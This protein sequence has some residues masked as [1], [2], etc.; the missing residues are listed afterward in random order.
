MMTEDHYPKGSEWRIWDLHVH[1]PAS[2]SVGG[3]FDDFVIQLGNSRCNVVGI[4]DYFS[5]NGYKT[6]QSYLNG[7]STPDQISD[8]YSDAL[9][10]LRKKTI[11]PVVECRMTNIVQG[12]D[13]KGNPRINFHI[14]FDNELPIDEI[15]TLIRAFN[16]SNDTTIGSKYNDAEFLLNKVSV[17]FNQVYKILN[18]NPELTNRHLIWIPYDEYG[19]IG[20][21]NPDSDSML[22]EGFINKAD[23]LGSS[24]KKQAEFFLWKHN[25]FKDEDFRGWFGRKKPCIKGSDSH[26][27]K[28]KIG[29]LKDNNSQPTNK[30][31][32]IKADPTFNGLKQIVHEPEN[33]VFIGEKPPKLSHFEQRK[34]NYLSKLAIRP[35]GSSSADFG[36][37]DT[38]IELN[39]DMVAVIGNKGNGKSALLDILALAGNTQNSAHF[40][41]LNKGKFREKGG[42]LASQFTVT[43]TWA[44]GTQTS[45]KLNEDPDPDQIEKLRYLPQ[46]YLEKICTEITPDLKSQFQQE[47]RNVIF[48]HIDKPNRLGKNSLDDLI[49]YHVEEI[50]DRISQLKAEIRKLNRDIV[51]LEL[52][53]TDEALRKLEAKLKEKQGQLVAFESQKPKEVKAPTTES[54]DKELTDLKNKINEKQEQLDKLNQQIETENRRKSDLT[55]K[56]ATARKVSEK[57][58][59]L[60]D[61]IRSVKMEVAEDLKLVG[62]SVDNV[63]SHNIQHSVVTKA[64]SNLEQELAKCEQRLATNNP[65]SLVRQAEIFQKQLAEHR[66]K[67]DEPTRLY[68]AYLKELG[69]WNKRKTE[70]IG[71]VET[72]DTQKFL[73]KQISDHKLIPEKIQ[74]L[75][76]RRQEHCLQIHAELK[77]M[78][79]IYQT[80]FAPLSELIR[81]HPII[82]EQ[83]KLSFETTISSG[84]LRDQLFE[85][86]I[87]QDVIGTFQSKEEGS[88]L[89]DNLLDDMDS[90]DAHSVTEFVGKVSDS[91]KWN[92]KLNPAQPSD[93]EKQLRKNV[94]RAD[95]YDFLWSLEYLKPEFA[96]RMDGKNLSQLSPG[97]RGLLLLVFFL[98]L[99]KG[100]VPIII[101]QPEENL[102]NQTVYNLL[103][104]A[105]QDVK[106]RRQVIMVTHSPNIAVVCDADQIIYCEIDRANNNKVRYIT[107]SI[108]AEKLNQAALDVLEGTLPSFENRRMKYYQH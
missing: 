99:D 1:S 36:W 10:K 58:K 75:E 55:Q 97:E 28:D 29:N 94:N 103:A 60:E 65:K 105:V 2:H 6:I 59:G 5:V 35:N 19:G 87:R 104:P 38:E 51:K 54:E 98:L 23:I 26:S 7:S 25:K 47:I 88:A 74:N 40:S 16:L 102:D 45:L 46:S 62:L 91:I 89:L 76:K 95:L 53:S 92:K 108:E 20:D 12:R 93:I 96:L 3:G 44:D 79:D 67:L 34:F 33:R 43:A 49:D 90:S 63:I 107:G 11:L 48:S 41:F 71:D 13:G 14:I 17:D 85:N 80:L 101:D 73:E 81:T 42:R 64:I 31:C 4:N 100:E 32:W 86:H 69:A 24:N 18:Q 27:I 61:R 106:Q 57:L 39:H 21:I 72:S 22:K 66:K 50:R 52:A 15:E 68:Q 82:A 9:E 30:Y 83:M 37:F 77:G 70:L 84:E 8:A 56:V 78:E